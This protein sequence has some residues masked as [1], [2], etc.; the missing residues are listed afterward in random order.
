VEEKPPD[1]FV[2][3]LHEHDNSRSIEP[4]VPVAGDNLS[5][6]KRQLRLKSH[7]EQFNEGLNDKSLLSRSS[8]VLKLLLQR[9]C[10][11]LYSFNR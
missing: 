1:N 6:D 5:G 11:G 8:F 4:H 10:H 2:E 9:D 7:G 3:D